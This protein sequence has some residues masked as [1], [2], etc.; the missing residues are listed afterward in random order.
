MDEATTAVLAIQAMPPVAPKPHAPK[1]S[2]DA[3]APTE[4]HVALRSPPTLDVPPPRESQMD[5]IERGLGDLQRAIEKLQR[6]VD[7]M[8]AAIARTITRK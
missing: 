7:A 2:N 1:R 8:D 5:R 3:E 6:R 4:V